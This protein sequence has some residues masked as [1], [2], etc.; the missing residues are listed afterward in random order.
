MDDGRPTI[1]CEACDGEGALANVPDNLGSTQETWGV[2]VWLG[3]LELLE[4]MFEN[5]EKYHGVD[6]S[7]AKHAIAR[8]RKAAAPCPKCWGTGDRPMTDEEWSD[9]SA[10]RFSDQCEGEPPVSLDEQ[11]ASAWKLKQELRR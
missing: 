4:S 2:S 11:H 3:R 6:V 7:A 8:Y 10:D 1:E 9:W 5:I